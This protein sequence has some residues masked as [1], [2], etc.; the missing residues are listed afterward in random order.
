MRAMPYDPRHV[1][2]AGAAAPLLL[3]PGHRWQE[4][5]PA[6]NPDR[7]DPLWSIE[8]VRRDREHVD[9]EGLHVHR[10]LPRRLHGVGVDK[11]ASRTGD[12][13]DLGN[14]LHGSDLVVR[15]HERY[16]GGIVPECR[17]EVVRRH[18]AGVANR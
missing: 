13:G 1:L 16:E 14:R 4:A 9:A 10:N 15:V 5:N 2:G 17:L 12:L 11:G 6:P 7:P 3:A 8:L 18:D